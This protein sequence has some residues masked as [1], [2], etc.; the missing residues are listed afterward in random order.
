MPALFHLSRLS[1][2]GIRGSDADAILH[3][4]TTNAV[5]TL[6]SNQGCETFI[7]DVRGKTLGHGYLYRVDSEAGNSEAGNSEPGETHRFRYVGAAGQ[8]QRIVDH[9]DKY[10]IR[11]D[12][13]PEVLDAKYQGLVIPAESVDTLKAEALESAG[14]FSSRPTQASP[15]DTV[16]S[17]NAGGPTYAVGCWAQ[18]IAGVD[19][20]VHQTEYL[21]PGTLLVLVNAAEADALLESLR[22]LGWTVADESAFHQARVAAGFPWYGIDLDEK[23]LPQEADRDSRAV[24]FTKGCY[25]GQETVARLDALGQVQR[26]LVLWSIQGGTPCS[27]STLDHNGKTVGRLTSV[28]VSSDSV[29]GSDSVSDNN[30]ATDSDPT[31]WIAIGY[32]RRS[33]FE[34]GAVAEGVENEAGKPYTALVIGPTVSP[35]PGN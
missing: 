16:C 32:A 34:P 11:E 21:G 27:G 10:T 5:K 3:N 24:S 7:T 18:T 22:G 4:V 9:M 12:A 30:P 25:L 8:S 1:I 17:A 13:V 29:S 33:H 6:A 14:Q 15:T 23:N 26:K 20:F 31:G 19:C 28:A 35:D 2:I